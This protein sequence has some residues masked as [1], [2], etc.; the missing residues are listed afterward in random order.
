VP[1]VRATFDKAE[2]RGLQRLLGRFSVLLVARAEPLYLGRGRSPELPAKT[3]FHLW[4]AVQ[5]VIANGRE[6]YLAAMENPRSLAQVL[7]GLTAPSGLYLLSIFRYESMIFEAQKLRLVTAFSAPHDE[8]AK[9]RVAHSTANMTPFE[10]KLARMAE[11]F[12]GYFSVMPFL[13]D[14]FKGPRFDSGYP[15]RYPSFR[16]LDSGEVVVRAYAS[17]ENPPSSAQTMPA[18]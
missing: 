15:E 17:G 10:Q 9:R 8:E 7:E 14:G 16:Q 6:A 5:Q 4:M 12:S 13:R 2:L 18:E 3:Y 1:K 11:S